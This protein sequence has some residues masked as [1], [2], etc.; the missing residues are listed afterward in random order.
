MG[1]GRGGAAVAAESEEAGGG[2][3]CDERN[4]ETAAMAGRWGRRRG[5]M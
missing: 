1:R 4:V 3:A 2:T 5:G